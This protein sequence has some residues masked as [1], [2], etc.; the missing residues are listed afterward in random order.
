[1]LQTRLPTLATRGALRLV[2]WGAALA[3]LLSSPLAGAAVRTDVADAVD[4]II[5]GE[6]E[7]DD[8]FDLYVGADFEFAFHWGKIT[9]E[10][11]NLQGRRID[12]C[13]AADSR[14][15]LPVYELAWSRNYQKINVYAEIGIF[16]DLSTTVRMPIIF[17]D[18]IAFD[19]A[20]GIDA[21]TSSVDTGGGRWTI[22]NH[23]TVGKRSGP[24]ALEWGFR[25]APLSDVR[26]DSKPMWVIYGHWAIPFTADTYFPNANEAQRRVGA[27]Q[28]ASESQPAPMGDGVHRLKFG[29]AF[30]RRIAN[31]GMI[32]ISDTNDRRG[33]IDPYFDL[34]Y[35][36]PFPTVSHSPESL[37]RNAGEDLPNGSGSYFGSDPSH[38]GEIATGFEVVPYE[39]LRDGHKISIDIGFRGA[40]VTNGRNYS[41]LTIPV[42]EL[43]YTEQYFVMGGEIGIVAEIASYIRFTLGFRV[44][45]ASEHFLTMET[46]GEDLDGNNRVDDPEDGPTNDKRN[47]YYCGYQDGDTCRTAGVPSYDQIGY[48]FKSEEQVVATILTG[49]L[50]T[51]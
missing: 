37:V 39:S 51:F 19:Y 5:I 12:G 43:T 48:R 11:I 8:P 50:V 18:T 49:L 40:F 35:T 38:L 23:D 30:S 28:P 10:P 16:H 13:S 3:L 1:M 29:M 20:N 15:C 21:G 9:R 26:D 6:T 41:E 32:G 42:Q 34:A 36:A 46:A 22:F 14:L 24:G 2:R 17:N 45:Y 27:T 7:R 47:P 44:Q 33:Y 25:W 4:T 31:F